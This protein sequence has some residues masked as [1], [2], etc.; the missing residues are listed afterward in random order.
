MA[1]G[2]TAPGTGLK[3]NAKGVLINTD[4]EAA[5]G[6]SA[7]VR[8]RHALGENFNDFAVMYGTGVMEN[9]T[10][11][12]SLAYAQTGTSV[13]DR[14]R[15]RVVENPVLAL[16]EKWALSAALIYESADS[17]TGQDARSHWYSVGARPIYYFTDHY[18][19]ALE[20]GFSDVKVDSET[21]GDGSKAGD[22]TMTR[23]TIAPEMAIGKG[24]FARPV[25]RAYATHTWWNKANED[26]TN[27]GSMLGALNAQNIT[28]L[29]GRLEETQVGLEGEIWF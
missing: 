7:G 2:Y 21:N 22:R 25:L 20:A 11:D 15:L 19:L 27:P 17:G 13:K 5:A 29:N 24:Y 6:A 1:G 16:S 14:K 28:A 26:T 8:W 23:L 18:H 12:N 10:M 3:P 9:F 4:F